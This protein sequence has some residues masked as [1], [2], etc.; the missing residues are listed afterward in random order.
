MER[1]NRSRVVI[2]G[3]MV[4]IMAG[5]LLAQDWPQWRG[6]DRDGKVEGFTAPQ[7][8]PSELTRKWTTTVGQGD[9]TPA[10]VGDKLHVF[11]RQGDDEV[12][13]CLNAAGARRR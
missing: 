11:A 1:T 5:G 8:W 7:Q 3:C 10:L 2:V 6:P 12:T 13:L 4:L 9:A